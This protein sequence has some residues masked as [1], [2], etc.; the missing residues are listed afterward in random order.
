MS[1]ISALSDQYVV[2]T[3]ALDPMLATFWGV[4]GH[5]DALTDYSPEGWA[6]RLELHRATICSLQEVTTDSRRD[7]IAAEVV[8]ERA[9]AERDLIESGEYH[10]W[11]NTFNT[12]HQSRP[13]G[14]RLHAA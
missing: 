6:A 8:R 9:E 13:R 7:R 2:E 12:H 10:R 3:A 4:A 11:L 1:G 14:L 5:D